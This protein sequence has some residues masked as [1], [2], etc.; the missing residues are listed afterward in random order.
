MKKMLKL[1]II[2]RPINEEHG[3]LLFGLDRETDRHI[4]EMLTAQHKTE[5]LVIWEGK[6]VS[7]MKKK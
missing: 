7:H 2:A 1:H 3:K 5:T 6:I 4:D